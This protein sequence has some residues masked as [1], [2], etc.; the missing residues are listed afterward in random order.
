MKMAKS[1]LLTV[2]IS[3]RC[4]DDIEYKGTTATLSAVRTDLKSIID[5][6]ELCGRRLFRCWIN[7]LETSLEGTQD[8]WDKCLEEVKD[9]D[10]V[11]VLYNGNAGWA[12]NAGGIGI[13]HAE[14]KTALETGPAKV[15]L[16]QLPFVDPAL[17]KS[18]LPNTANGRMKQYVDQQNLFRG[19]EIVNG[20]KLIDEAQRTLATVVIDLAKTGVLDT[21]RGRF[22]SGQALDW[23]RFDFS[24]RKEAMESVM[25][26]ALQQRNGASSVGKLDFVKLE[27]K[28]VLFRCHAVPAAMTVAAAREMV[29]MPFLKDHDFAGDLSGSK[30]GPVHLIACHKSVSESQAINLLGFPDATIVEP[31]FGIYVADRIQ[32]I[33]LLLLRNC[34]DET[35]T[36]HAVQRAFDWLERSGEAEFLVQRAVSRTRIIKAIA[37][38]SAT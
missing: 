2:M 6:L 11:M 29:G 16:L 1:K 33:Q 19:K 8:S 17:K 5:K 13:C 18:S 15:R 22:D 27:S 31:P 12:T 14:L 26:Q 9:A 32:N 4:N 21:R 36:R 28:N 24:E 25:R 7:E 30:I 35:T 20:E 23:S 10:I 3:S 37:K 38:E 34:R